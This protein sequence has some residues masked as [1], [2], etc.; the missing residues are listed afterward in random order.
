VKELKNI[1]ISTVA[2]NAGTESAALLEDRSL[3]R[4]CADG[5]YRVILCFPKQLASPK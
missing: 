5:K 3:W 2:L 4:E 1:E